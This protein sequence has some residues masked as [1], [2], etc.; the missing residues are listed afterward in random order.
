MTHSTTPAGRL[1]DAVITA[2][3]LF[4]IV[5]CLYPLLYVFSMSISDPLAAAAQEVWLLPKGFSLNAYNLVFENP[6]IWTAYFNTLWYTVAGTAFNVLMTITLAYPLSRR[7][8]FLRGPI[9]FLVVFTM[10]FSGGL[11]PTFIL[12][13][14]L[15][16]YNTRWALIILGAIGVWYVIIARTY[17]STIP[18]SLIES[19]KLDGANDIRIFWTVILPLSKP[20]IA[21]LVLFYAVGHWNSYFSALIYLPNKDL[22]PLQLYLVKVLVENTGLADSVMP[23]EEKS[24]AIMQIKYAIIIVATLPILFVYPFL[25]KYFVKGVMIGA[26]K[27]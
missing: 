22:Q 9:T 4:V 7:S 18:E 17:F 21:V 8:F 19:A 1:A 20:I 5:I 26:I 11:I 23:S 16:L 15:G 3:M 25:Q 6:D 13:N 27:G 14:N 24:L 10:L 12:V 2:I